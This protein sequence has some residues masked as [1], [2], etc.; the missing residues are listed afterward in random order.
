MLYRSATSFGSP[1][2]TTGGDE[3]SSQANSALGLI[4]V[5]G[6]AAALEAADAMVKSAY[7]GEVVRQQPG[8]GLITVMVRGDVG[9]VQAALEAGTAAAKIVGKVVSTKVIPRPDDAVLDILQ[10]A[11]V[12]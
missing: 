9:S 6:L 5:I 11:P 10:R 12:R 7:V 3:V 8:G 1:S 4:E 2:P